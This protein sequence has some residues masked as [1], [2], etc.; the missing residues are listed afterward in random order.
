[1][2]VMK[3]SAIGI[4]QSSWSGKPRAMAVPLLARAEK[5]ATSTYRCLADLLAALVSDNVRPSPTSASSAFQ[6]LAF[7]LP[8][9]TV[10]GGDG[11][12]DR[13]EVA[14]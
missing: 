13:D 1:M 8:S 6:T 4:E 7:M 12:R 10:L 3:S 14:D 2:P 9:L 5:V 11:V